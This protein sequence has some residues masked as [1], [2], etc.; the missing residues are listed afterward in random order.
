MSRPPHSTPSCAAPSCIAWCCCS[1]NAGC[2]LLLLLQCCSLPLV[3]GAAAAS[4][5]ATAC[6]CLLLLLL[7]HPL[8]ISSAQALRNWTKTN[9]CGGQTC[10]LWCFAAAAAAAAAVEPLLL[11]P[12]LLLLS[13]LLC[14]SRCC[15]CCRRRRA[16][17]S[18][19]SQHCGSSAESG[20]TGCAP[21]LLPW[22]SLGEYCVIASM[23]ARAAVRS[24][25]AWS[26]SAR[27]RR[28]RGSNVGRPCHRST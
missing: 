16:V 17:S 13:A 14:C 20:R 4:T 1:A 25:A 24:S 8:S 21:L 10:E 11:P 9:S 26:T 28:M 15:S 2:S 27:A 22:A 23:C 18:R 5:T 12:L 19:Q 6:N 3:A 7:L